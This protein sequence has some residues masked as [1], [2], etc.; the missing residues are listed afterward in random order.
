MIVANAHVSV[1]F[2]LRFRSTPALVST[3]RNLAHAEPCKS[4]GC[5]RPVKV[6]GPRLERSASAASQSVTGS[7]RVSDDIAALNKRRMSGSNLAKTRHFA[8]EAD[9]TL[10]RIFRKRSNKRQDVVDAD[11]KP[12]G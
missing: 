2:C 1:M 12:A 5:L 6:L 7:P 9:G 11:D 10:Q 3:S 8:V 4:V